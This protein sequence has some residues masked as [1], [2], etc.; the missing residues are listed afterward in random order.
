MS[1]RNELDR[2]Y[3]LQAQKVF[4]QRQMLL[5]TLDEITVARSMLH[6]GDPGF[7]GVYTAIPTICQKDKNVCSILAF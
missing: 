5:E 6:N 7:N 2:L 3:K 1:I 4:V